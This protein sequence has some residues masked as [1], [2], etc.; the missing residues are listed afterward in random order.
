[1]PKESI[2]GCTKRSR[3]CNFSPPTKWCENINFD[4]DRGMTVLHWMAEYGHVDAIVEPLQIGADIKDETWAGVNVL[5]LAVSSG[6]LDA[7]DTLL[8]HGADVNKPMRDGATP[9]NDTFTTCHNDIYAT[10]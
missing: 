9:I 7:V 10:L 8:Q 4:K 2:Q 5:H 3:K 6:K 1:M